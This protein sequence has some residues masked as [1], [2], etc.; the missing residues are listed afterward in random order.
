MD[1]SF[2]HNFP[3]VWE[4]EAHSILLA[5]RAAGRQWVSVVWGNSA[6]VQN[7]LHC[8]DL[9]VHNVLPELLAGSRVVF[10]GP[11]VGVQIPGG[12]RQSVSLGLEDTWRRSD[13]IQR[14]TYYQLAK[15]IDWCNIGGILM[16]FEKKEVFRGFNE[17]EL[18]LFSLGI[19]LWYCELWQQKT[20]RTY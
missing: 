19:H 5:D 17:W 4:T 14:W 16:T 12:H 20:E 18:N 13:G 10:I 7:H 2:C 3:E 6:L 8:K 1:G 9:N 11:I 15:P